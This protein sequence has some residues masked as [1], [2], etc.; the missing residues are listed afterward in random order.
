MT[1][2][3]SEL[4]PR[5]SREVRTEQVRPGRY[6]GEVDISEDANGLWLRATCRGRPDKVSVQRGRR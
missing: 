1:Q 2:M 3:T 4:T 6:Y 5:T